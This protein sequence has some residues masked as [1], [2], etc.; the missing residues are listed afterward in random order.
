MPQGWN[1]RKLIIMEDLARIKFTIH[2]HL[3]NLLLRTGDAEIVEDNVWK[4]HFWGICD[5][6]GKILMKIRKE[7]Y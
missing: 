6:K 4:D 7:L 1:E 2:L 3:K 5:G